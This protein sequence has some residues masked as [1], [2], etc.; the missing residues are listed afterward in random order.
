MQPL[1]EVPTFRLSKRSSHFPQCF[2]FT[3][4]YYYYS[5]FKSFPPLHP[6]AKKRKVTIPYVI[7]IYIQY[8]T[9]TTI[10]IENKRVFVGVGAMDFHTHSLGQAK[11]KQSKAKQSSPFLCQMKADKILIGYLKPKK[12]RIREIGED[13]LKHRVLATKTH[14]ATNDWTSFYEI[15]QTQPT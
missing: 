14:C 6:W 5:F 8:S 7:D 2:S 11:L 13:H 3:L 9:T 4:Y 15:L 1:K 10:K 12:K